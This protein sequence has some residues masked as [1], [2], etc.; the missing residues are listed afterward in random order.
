MEA[1]AG[2]EAGVGTVGIGAETVGAGAETVGDEAGTVG[3]GAETEVG[4]V[5]AGAGTVGALARRAGAGIRVAYKF[6]AKKEAYKDQDKSRVQTLCP[7]PC[8]VTV[9][10]SSQPPV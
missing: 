5:G 7:R 2:A 6:K 9:S 8:S 3:V 1:G 4:T 10:W